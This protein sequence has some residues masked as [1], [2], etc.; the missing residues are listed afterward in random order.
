MFLF[1]YV[2]EAFYVL[3]LTNKSSPP[4]RFPL[5]ARGDAAP[6]VSVLPYGPGTEDEER[7]EL[8]TT[9]LRVLQKWVWKVALMTVVGGNRDVCHRHSESFLGYLVALFV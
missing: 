2:L 6:S 5:P 8:S 9:G 7:A 3:R 1:P 4:L